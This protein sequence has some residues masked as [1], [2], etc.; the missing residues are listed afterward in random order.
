MTTDEAAEREPLMLAATNDTA[1]ESI[2]DSIRA[3]RAQHAQE[4]HY[5]VDVPGYDGLLVL[6]LEPIPGRTL[7]ALVDRREKSRLPERD[8]NLNAD[9][10]IV[11]CREVLG[12]NDVA[13][14]LVTLPGSDGEPVRIDVRLAEL[15]QMPVTP[16]TTAREVLRLIFEGANS[17]DVAIIAAG[18]EYM[19]WARSADDDVDRELLGES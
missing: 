2:L 8:F 13:D 7:A 12:R 11:A 3:K 4:R 14:P 10:V 16:Q 19:E 9:V 5:D 18:G 15:L 17:P 6:R 1:A